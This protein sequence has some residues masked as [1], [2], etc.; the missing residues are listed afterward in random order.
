LVAAAGKLEQMIN[1]AYMLD[2]FWQSGRQPVAAFKIVLHICAT[3]TFEF[4]K[5]KKKK[6]K[7][8]LIAQK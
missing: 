4:S 2:A 8:K 3:I 1:K 6:K 5:K 7:L